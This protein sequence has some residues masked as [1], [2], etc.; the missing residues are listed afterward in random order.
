FQIKLGLFQLLFYH[1]NH[2][3]RSSGLVCSIRLPYTNTRG[4]HMNLTQPTEENLKYILE[5]LSKK[6]DV[7]NK[8]VLDPKGYDLAKY[9]DIKL[10]YDVL[11]KKD[12]LSASETQ[13]F[14]DEL[15]K[16]RKN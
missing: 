15:R 11:M 6:V 13:A 12:K 2:T 10:M 4:V 14:I 3:K 5:Q 9:E 16:V 7:A 1:N 8:I